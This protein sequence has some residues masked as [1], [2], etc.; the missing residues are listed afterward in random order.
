MLGDWENFREEEIPQ[1][2]DRW[3]QVL[4][5]LKANFNQQKLAERGF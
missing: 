2:L 3:R 1:D 4:L 5:R